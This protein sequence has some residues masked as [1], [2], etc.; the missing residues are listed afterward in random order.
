MDKF[1][2]NVAIVV[3][4]RAGE[5]LIG[6]RADILSVWQ[7]PQGGVD[8]GESEV[9]AV[10]RELREETSLE[11]VEILGVN[12]EAIKYKWPEGFSYGDYIGQSQ[13]YF[14][15]RVDEPTD[16]DF[17][18]IKTKEFSSFKWVYPEEFFSILT[19]FKKEAYIKGISYFLQNYKQ[20]F[21]NV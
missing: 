8:K 16:I 11:V 4:N 10:K 18:K 21:K 19:G 13:K 20:Y 9:E 17:K 2:L 15:V 1:R 7:I 12:P 6:E 14:L 5:I 3:V